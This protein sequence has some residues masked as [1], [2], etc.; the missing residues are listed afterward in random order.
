MRICKVIVSVAL[1]IGLALSLAGCDTPAKQM[2][3]E[4]TH[5]YASGV[6]YVECGMCG[7][8]VVQWWYVSNNDNEL[9]EVC[10]YC[11]L[12]ARDM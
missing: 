11:Y 1:T 6:Y 7:A 3:P 12:E 2:E 5:R 8:H 10:E 9:I 4:G